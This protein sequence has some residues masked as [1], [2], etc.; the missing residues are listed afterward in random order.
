[1]G[2]THESEVM[3]A[4]TAEDFAEAIARVCTDRALWQALSEKGGAS[5]AGR[6]TPDVAEAALRDV[7]APW[8][9]EGDLETVG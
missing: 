4:E 5:L 7:L 1:M 9:N 2:L 6:F 3:V 8:L